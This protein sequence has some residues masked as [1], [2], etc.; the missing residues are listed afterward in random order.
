MLTEEASPQHRGLN[1]CRSRNYLSLPPGSPVGFSSTG[2]GVSRV[3]VL[4]ILFLST[5]SSMVPACVRVLNDVAAGRCVFVRQTVF[6]GGSSHNRGAFAV[7]C[8]AWDGQLPSWPL[9]GG[10]KGFLRHRT[11]SGSASFESERCLT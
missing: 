9:A 11:C 3:N 8:G 7:L 1:S 10:R 2:R 4:P 5:V 6:A